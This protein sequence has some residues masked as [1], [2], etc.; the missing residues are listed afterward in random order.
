MRVHIA[1]GLFLLASFSLLFWQL[2]V[3][4]GDKPLTQAAYAQSSCPSNAQGDADCNGKI[5]DADYT[6]WRAHYKGENTTGDADFNDDTKTDMKDFEIWR[7]GRYGSGPVSTPTG[8]TDPTP[9]SGPLGSCGCDLGVVTQNSCAQETTAICT[10][11]FSCECQKTEKL[12]ITPTP[13]NCLQVLT[14]AYNPTTGE[15]R[16]FPSSCL[17]DGWVRGCPGPTSTPI[18]PTS[19]CKDVSCGSTAAPTPTIQVPACSECGSAY[20]SKP[21]NVCTGEFSCIGT[22][23]CQAV[24]TTCTINGVSNTNCYKAVCASNTDI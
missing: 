20:D 15:C 17:P 22:Q 24:Q 8:T 2:R 23:T 3:T 5:E 4:V 13:A 12:T 9:T 19:L 14:R 10:D 16:N 7:R 18:R 6:I 21:G 11:K 1:V